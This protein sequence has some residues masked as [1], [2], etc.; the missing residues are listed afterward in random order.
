M[1]IWQSL[2]KNI[3]PEKQAQE[4][5]EEYLL[6]GYLNKTLHEMLQIKDEVIIRFYNLISE[7]STIESPVKNSAASRWMT[8]SDFCFVNVRATGLNNE[9]GNFIQAAKILPC[10]RAESIHLGPFTNYEF[11]VIYAVSSLISIDSRLIHNGIKLTPDDQL[12]AFVQA[13]HLLN[14]TIGFDIEPHV[15]QFSTPVLIQPELFRWIKLSDDKNSLMENLSQEEILTEE[16][17]AKIQN[18]VSGKVERILSEAK[19]NTFERETSD[20]LLL[21]EHKKNAYIKCIKELIEFGFWTIPSQSW[22]CKGVPEFSHYNHQHNYPVFNYTDE[23]GKDYSESAYHILTPIK[24]YTGLKCNKAPVSPQ[25]YTAGCDFFNS[26]FNY[27]RDKFSFDFVRYDSVDH[28]FDS[29]NEGSPLSDRPT[30]EILKSCIIN[31][32]L[33]DKPYIGNLAERMGN[34]IEEY[35]SLGYDLMLGNDMLQKADI[36][37]VNKSFEI[38]DRL[39][40]LNSKSEKRFSV[41]FA[42]DTHDTGNPAFWGEPL[43]KAVGREQMHLRHFFS[44][45]GSSG[46]GYRPKYEAMGSQDLSYG[47]YESNIKDKN[48]NWVGDKEYNLGYHFIEDIFSKYKTDILSG[49]MTERILNTAVCLWTI[50]SGKYSLIPVISFNEAVEDF[51]LPLEGEIIK[52]KTKIIEYNFGTRTTNIQEVNNNY[53]MISKLSISSPRLIVI[54]FTS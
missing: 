17:Q 19:I 26:I 22:A 1:N 31:S 50:K 51:L 36:E 43:V 30:S 7:K 25:I 34:E 10:I 46:K 13:V 33:P 32:K 42:V 41:T 39:T 14:K 23:N 53:I 49:E 40:N 52:G 15:S 45:F 18:E 21:E 37:L 2:A 6:N 28:I 35:S 29:E 12:K 44:R 24:F 9:H 27:W 38:Y 11:G 48:L 8:T 54:E 47:L 4:L 16:N 20:T 3:S 5:Y